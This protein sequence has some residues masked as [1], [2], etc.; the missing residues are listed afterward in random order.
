MSTELPHTFSFKQV[1]L[2]SEGMRVMGMGTRTAP[3]KA[4]RAVSSSMHAICY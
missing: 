4:C 2:S 1:S 3:A